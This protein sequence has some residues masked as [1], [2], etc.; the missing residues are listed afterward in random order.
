L[1]SLQYGYACQYYSADDKTAFVQSL[2]TIR[3]ESEKQGILPFVS[4]DIHGFEEG[5][6]LPSEEIMSWLE[7]CDLLRAVNIASNTNLMV[8][9]SSC[10]G[11]HAI[12]ALAQSAITQA[13]AVIPVSFNTLIGPQN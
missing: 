5:I 2:N 13:A 3:V 11:F 9:L 8:R 7:S 12:K 1:L 4:F 6:K 10:F